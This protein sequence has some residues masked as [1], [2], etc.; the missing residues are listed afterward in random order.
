[1]TAPEKR[2]NLQSLRRLSIELSFAS[3]QASE[4]IGALPP[5][6]GRKATD[7][8]GGIRNLEVQLFTYMKPYN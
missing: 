8:V 6:N 7:T 2:T 4:V 1:V 3:M 5:L